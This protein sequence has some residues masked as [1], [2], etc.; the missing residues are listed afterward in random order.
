MAPKTGPIS[1]GP[2]QQAGNHFHHLYA[3]T[4]AMELLQG[5]SGVHSVSLE[6]FGSGRVAQD[7]LDV[8]VE[9][10]NEVEFIQVKWSQ[11][12][13]LRPTACWEIVKH[14]WNCAQKQDSAG[15]G[16]EITLF[17]NRSAGAKLR[18]Q[19]ELLEQWKLLSEQD[20]R[21]IL[22]NENATDDISQK[23]LHEL[24]QIT[25]TTKSEPISMLIISAGML[26]ANNSAHPL[27]PTPVGPKSISA[28]FLLDCIT[29]NS[30]LILI[31]QI[32]L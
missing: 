30:I 18:R 17:T 13:P 32:L 6:G 20:L 22:E 11:T 29:G 1:G 15:R 28:Y 2:A 10:D 26:S 8:V 31:I 16:I 9:G 5:G 14:L 27:L 19:L 12:Q 23:L 4:R 3:A 24:S 21:G 7:A 25:G